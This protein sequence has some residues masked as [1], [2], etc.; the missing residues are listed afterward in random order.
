VFRLNP[1]AGVP[2]YVQL[3]EQVKHAIAIGALRPG[4]Q[5]PTVRRLAEQLVINP[6]TVVRTYRELQH[7]GI[8]ELKQGSGAYIRDSPAAPTRITR[9][10]Q[11]IV[12]SAVERLE[13]EGLGEHEIR[14][15]FEGELATRRAGGLM[16]Q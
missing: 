5:L 14:R 11:Q 15:L 7:E 4:D 13:T 12:A 3:K 9:K 2:V 10:A 8:V 1:A 16:E 6:N